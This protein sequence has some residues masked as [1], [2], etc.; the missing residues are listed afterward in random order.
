MV[1]LHYLS[2]VLMVAI[3]TGCEPNLFAG[4]ASVGG[5]GKPDGS[6]T[7]VDEHSVIDKTIVYGATVQ[8][9]CGDLQRTMQ[10]VDVAGQPLATGSKQDAPTTI[11]VQIV[12]ENLSSEP[13]SE[14]WANCRLP[15]K[16]ADASGKTL[17]DNQVFECPQSASTR[18]WGS[19]EVKQLQLRALI[20][21]RPDDYAVHYQAPVIAAKA[22]SK[23]EL[24][25][26]S[27]APL[28]LPYTIEKK[29]VE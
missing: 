7:A 24:T 5:S 4:G 19:K 29:Q 6:H 23:D 3:L 14:E 9:Q 17:E 8:D 21:G 27:C 26:Y 1:K 18:T 12:L 13:I 10:F 22:G 25:V 20:S 11:H 2:Y 16:I 15:T 28:S